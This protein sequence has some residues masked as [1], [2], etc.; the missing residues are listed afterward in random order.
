MWTTVHRD[1]FKV[2][3]HHFIISHK[4]FFFYF[5]LEK[6]IF[7]EV[8]EAEPKESCDTYQYVYRIDDR[9]PSVI[10]NEGFQPREK[11]PV[12]ATVC[13]HLYKTT[14]TFVSTTHIYPGYTYPYETKDADDFNQ[15]S[16]LMT[17]LEK[18]E[19]IFYVYKIKTDSTFYNAMDSIEMLKKNHRFIKED[20]QKIEDCIELFGYQKE[21]IAT[22]G[23]HPELIE[24]CMGWKYYNCKG[25]RPMVKLYKK[26]DYFND[27]FI[28]ISNEQP[29]QII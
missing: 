7:A 22:Q 17:D 4:Y 5:Q 10:F 16:E 15:I 13:S 14:M 11:E 12:N 26:N 21:L 23:I 28:G 20:R 27:R 18:N 25:Y 9:P 1:F 24:S 29:Y 19:D 6:G 8:F 3:S 2:F